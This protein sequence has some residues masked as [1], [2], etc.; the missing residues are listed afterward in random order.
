MP[1]H[2]TRA[3]QTTPPVTAQA[4]ARTS[5]GLIWRLSVLTLSLARRRLLR[6]AGED[7]LAVLAGR[8]CLAHVR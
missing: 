2:R 6:E 1:D 8:Y 3:A 5:R 4:S 7:A